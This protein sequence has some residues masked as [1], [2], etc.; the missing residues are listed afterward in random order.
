MS[1]SLVC[2]EVN[3]ASVPTNTMWLHPGAT[4]DISVSMKGCI[5]YQKS[6]DS[7]RWIYVGDNKSVEMEAIGHFRLL[8]YTDFYLD[9]R[10][11][12]VVSSFRHNLVSVSYLDKLGNLCSFGNNELRLFLNSNIIGTDS[13]LDNHNL[14]MVDTV[15]SYSKSFNTESCGTKRKI[16]D[17]DSRALW[18]IRL[19]HIP[20][21]RAQ[22]LVSNEI[23]DSI[24]FTNFDICVE[25][26]KGKQTKTSRL[27]AYRTTNILELIHMDICGPFPTP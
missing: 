8:L 10:D 20:K 13:L 1:H 11:N 17:I 7:K 24:D 16:D 18:H 27:G 23:L 25:C 21:N 15:V 3:L 2:Y 19:T 26:G 12:C 22:R 4:T 6:I 5:R 9:F 14:Y